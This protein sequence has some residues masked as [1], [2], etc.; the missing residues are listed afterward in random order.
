[1]RGI[2]WVEGAEGAA[3]APRWTMTVELSN[4]QIAAA[5]ATAGGEVAPDS[6]SPEVICGVQQRVVWVADDVVPADKLV[7]V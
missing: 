1:M 4:S 6:V 3:A 2:F 7:S 5:A